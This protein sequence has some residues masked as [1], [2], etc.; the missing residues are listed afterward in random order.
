MQCLGLSEF[1]LV[2]G[3]SQIVIN[4]CGL[5]FSSLISLSLCVV[6]LYTATW[7]RSGQVV[8]FFLYDDDVYLFI[9]V[10]TSLEFCFCLIH[11]GTIK[12]LYT[13]QPDVRTYQSFVY[14]IYICRG[15][16]IKYRYVCV[17]VFWVELGAAK[18]PTHASIRLHKH[19]RK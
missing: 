4:F 9:I 13:P 6:F 17:C 15:S 19:S 16:I 8:I 12:I 14:Y 10:F 3:A 1:R 7:F 5:L 2:L 11:F 18:V